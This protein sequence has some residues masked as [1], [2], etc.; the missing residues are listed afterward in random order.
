LPDPGTVTTTGAD[1]GSVWTAILPA[2]TALVGVA[3][4]SVVSIVTTARNV[5]GQEDLQNQR[6]ARE[7]RA[8]RLATIATLRDLVQYAHAAGYAGQFNLKQWS[9]SVDALVTHVTDRDTV[10]GFSDEEWDAVT[11][12]ASE[13]RVGLTRLQNY[14]SNNPF[15]DGLNRTNEAV[16]LAQQ[17]YMTMVQ[18]V[19]LRLHQKL[20]TALE[21]VGRPIDAVE[22]RNVALL[23]DELRTRLGQ[24]PL[25]ETSANQPAPFQHR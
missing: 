6:F 16:D 3:V 12:V 13:A 5:R 20:R 24:R 18:D 15:R 14:A 17:Q 9:P 4:G 23:V 19:G 11:D 8:A 10:P 1:A 2:I 21:R 7:A 22:K 25:K